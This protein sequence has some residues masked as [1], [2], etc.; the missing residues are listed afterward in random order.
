MGIYLDYNASAPIDDRVL[1]KMVEVFRISYGNADSRTHEYG[2]NARKIVEEAREN[3]ASLLGIEK[4]EVF[5]TSGATE[6][7]NIAIQGLREFGIKKNKKHLIVSAIEHKAV[8]EA[9]KSLCPYGFEIEI[10]Y[11]NLSGRINAKEVCSKVRSDTLLVS[12]MHVNNE[13]GIIQ[14]VEEIGEFLENK[15]TLFHIDATQSFGKLV[16]ELKCIKY[17]MLAMS[18]HK[19]GGPQGI[20]ALILKRKRYRL[21][22][23]KPIMF[24]GAQEHGI[25]PGTLPVALIAG[26]GEACLIMKQEYTV[27]NEKCK[28]IKRTLI[29]LLDEAKLNYHLN[30]AQEYCVPST[31]NI[32]IYGVSSEALM[33]ASKQYCGISNG[34]ACNS[35]E[36][37]LSFV[38]KAMGIS[39]N[40]IESSLRISW[41]P[42]I[43]MNKLKK[44]FSYL[45]EVAKGLL[46]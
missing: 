20:G 40:E 41:G 36:Y 26:L 9:A 17:D 39:D 19:I 38:L 21:P 14:P 28:M 16:D 45:L 18:A 34:S 42:M 43:D 13:T 24:G 30:G 6:S 29:E 1:E 31:M 44:E 10:V 4:N 46:S 12:I 27:N 2:D 15:E 35:K 5:F 32:C 11:P 23:V 7:N 25:R 8:L 22:P 3:V 33:L 37:V